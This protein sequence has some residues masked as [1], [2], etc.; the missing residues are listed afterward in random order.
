MTEGVR[1]EGEGVRKGSGRR[2]GNVCDTGRDMRE[3]QE[4][5]GNIKLDQKSRVPFRS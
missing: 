3:R 4:E 2:N 5:S 1:G